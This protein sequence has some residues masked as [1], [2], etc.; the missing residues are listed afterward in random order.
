MR[1]DE[2]S[3]Y[4]D[5]RAEGYS[6][7][8]NEEFGNETRD[9]WIKKFEKF[10][11]TGEKMKCLEIG[12]GPGFLSILLAIDGNEVTSVDYSEE[13]LSKAE[14]NANNMG[15]ELDI[16][17]MDAQ[18]LEFPD[19]TF[20]LIVNRNVVWVL[21]EPEKAYAE[22]LRVLKPGGRIIIN[23]GNHY[24]HYY[25]DKYAK[26]RELR[27]KELGDKPH[28]FM[29]GVDPKPIDDI[30]RDLP[31]S[32]IERPGWDVEVFAGMGAS[33]IDVVP[34]LGILKDENGEEVRIV[35]HFDIC[36]TKAR[37]IV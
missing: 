33:E 10:R 5:K 32:R 6:L 14:E 13:M 2:I 9:L 8:V 27:K 24:L 25:N 37:E 3:N 1:L 20:D 11:P 18:K 35:N 19:E 21:E 12:C 16:M 15:V 22:W 34:A 26:F 23:D 7:S 29:L 4:W 36:V 30:A 17:K 28:R 31:L